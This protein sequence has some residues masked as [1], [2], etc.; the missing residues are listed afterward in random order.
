MNETMALIEQ[1]KLSADGKT[2]TMK[3]RLSDDEAGRETAEWLTAD[4]IEAPSDAAHV[5]RGKL[6][7]VGGLDAASG[8]DDPEGDQADAVA[9]AGADAV[10]GVFDSDDDHDD[11]DDQG[12]PAG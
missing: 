4:H 6:A 10:A 1:P 3:F 2:V 12:D 5:W 8:P 9:D 7:L 11:D